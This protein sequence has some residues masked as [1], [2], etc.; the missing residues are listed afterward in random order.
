MQINNGRSKEK[1]KT[2]IVSDGVLKHEQIRDLIREM[3]IGGELAPGSRVPS[4]NQMKR[5]FGV[6]HN[7]VREAIGSLVHEGL[8]YR[9]QGKGTYVAERRKR[10]VIGVAVPHLFS[11]TDP[12]NTLGYEVIAPLVTSIEDE[13]RKHDA[14]IML[15]LCQNNPALESQ[16][17]LG[18][19]EHN[20]S[21]VIAFIIGGKE[22][23]DSLEKLTA[24]G[25]PVVLI[26]RYIE[27]L[28][29][30]Y[31]VTNNYI[32]ARK[33]V[34]TIQEAGF[35]NILYVTLKPDNTTLRD[36]LAGVESAISKGTKIQKIIVEM[37]PLRPMN[38][39]RLLTL[40]YSKVK[41]A[42]SSAKSPFAIFSANSDLLTASW[43]AVR[44]LGFNEKD[45]LL[46]CF[47]D[48]PREVFNDTSA[49]LL[50]VIQPLDEIGRTG[51]Q[52]L[53]DKMHG[54]NTQKQTVL[55][56]FVETLDPPSPN[57][58]LIENLGAAYR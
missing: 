45:L 41:E 55:D 31:V 8:L 36:R 44:E 49:K 15:R 42:I 57:S 46:G 14:T 47:D 40:A 43:C 21:G 35:D 17:L 6:S 37:E 32:G 16:N 19:L 4:Q 51:V 27:G 58:V 29:L 18:L 12:R 3:I 5:Q 24:K 22:T 25:I 30:D 52:I 56:P 2:E 20:I 7:T 28:D 50:R 11:Q 38:I 39:A 26:D 53:M 9:I 33:A 34:E 54:K 48:I 23:T 10:T 13:A 1:Q